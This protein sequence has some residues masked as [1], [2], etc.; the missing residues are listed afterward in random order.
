MSDLNDSIKTP[1]VYLYNESGELLASSI[2]GLE[3]GVVDFNYEYD[4]EEEDICTIKIQAK[5]H[6]AIDNLNIRRNAVLI[7]KWGYVGGPLSNS[8]RVAVRDIASKYG[9][10]NIYTEYK[11]TDLTTALKYIN[12]Q[13]VRTMSLLD[14]LDNYASRSMKIVIQSGPDVIYKQGI[15]NQITTREEEDTQRIQMLYT[16]KDSGPIPPFD[17][18]V[19]PLMNGVKPS[20]PMPNPNNIIERGTWYADAENDIK[21]YFEK[22]RDIISVNRSPYNVL[23]ET[24]NSCPQGPW[25]ITGRGNTLLIHNR[26]LGNNLYK[27]YEYAGEHGELLDFTAET[28]YDNF[29]KQKISSTNMDPSSKGIANL[30][31]Y[32]NRLNSQ[33]TFPEIIQDKSISQEERDRQLRDFIIGYHDYKMFEIKINTFRAY[34]MANPNISNY[35]DAQISFSEAERNGDVSFDEDSGILAKKAYTDVIYVPEG[36]VNTSPLRGY[37]GKVIIYSIPVDD[38]IDTENEQNNTLRKLEME[39][40]EANIIIEGDPYIKS[41]MVIGILNVQKTHE[42][43]YYIKKCG[44]NITEQ[45]YRTTL[46][47]LKVKDSAVIKSLKAQSEIEK[48]QDGAISMKLPEFFLKQEKAFNRWKIKIVFKE[49]VGGYEYAKVGTGGYQEKQ[50]DTLDSILTQPDLNTDEQYS[51]I[52]KY[53]DDPRY[54]VYIEDRPITDPKDL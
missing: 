28:K 54:K 9:T 36:K 35:Q 33:R 41:E 45:G 37:M 32:L 22:E 29:E 26:N 15:Q 47:T 38:P 17:P 49:L 53:I 16:S 51:V 44:H 25:F 2:E 50:V 30:D 40:E 8:A 12:V 48:A 21:K 18:F 31:S 14:Y 1:I 3:L 24:L 27:N 13:D 23:Q 5:N 7:V 4:D 43:K 6:D 19:T 20:L 46:E 11:C 10:N 39:T 52:K 34:A 42:G